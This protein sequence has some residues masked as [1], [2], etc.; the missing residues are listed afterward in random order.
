MAQ[1]RARRLETERRRRGW[2]AAPA[3]QFIVD[4]GQPA[5][6]LSANRRV[7]VQAGAFDGSGRDWR[8]RRD[9]GQ[10]FDSSPS[11]SSLPR[12]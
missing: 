1:Q 11:S 12:Q 5:V 6:R 3:R 9:E 7:A 2:R 10:K 8:C 4:A